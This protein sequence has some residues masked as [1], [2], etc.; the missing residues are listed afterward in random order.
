VTSLWFVAETKFGKVCRTGRPR[1]KPCS[2]SCDPYGV[3]RILWRLGAGACAVFAVSGVASATESEASIKINSFVIT[4][5][6]CVGDAF[7]ESHQRT[8]GFGWIGICSSLSPLRLAVH[9]ESGKLCSYNESWLGCVEVSETGGQYVLDNISILF[10]G[11]EMADVARPHLWP[12]LHGAAGTS[13]AVT[14]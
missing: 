2:K 12:A 4:D 9:G 7:A 13:Q 5:G 11:F 8:E 3:S 1:L 6:I 14:R 10:P